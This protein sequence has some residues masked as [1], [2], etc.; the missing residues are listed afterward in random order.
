MIAFPEAAMSNRANNEPEVFMGDLLNI[1]NQNYLDDPKPVLKNKNCNKLK[2]AGKKRKAK[3]CKAKKNEILARKAIVHLWSWHALEESKLWSGKQEPSGPDS[4][5]D[6]G[7]TTD[8]FNVLH[9]YHD[10][11]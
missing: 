11:N 2:K 10:V 3:K 7:F 9:S 5:T 8:R 6:V 1:L 4:Y